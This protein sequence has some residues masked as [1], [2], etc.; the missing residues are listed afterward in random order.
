MP[1]RTFRRL[2][3]AAT[4]AASASTVALPPNFVSV[5]V[6]SNWNQ[7]VG[8]TFAPDGRMFVWEKGGRVWLVENGV[9]SAQPLIDISEE[10][11][12][13]RDF[14]LLGFAID[15][16]FYNNGYIYLLYVV[17]YHHL[18]FFGTP[19]YNPATNTYFR[20]TIGRLT[21]YQANAA[22]GFRT[23]NYNT[24]T[25][26]VGESITT[27]FPICH[28]SHGIGGL[29]F[30]ED[31]SL[32]ASCGDGAS[33][34]T[35]DS[36]GNINGSSN[37]AL[38][39]G[40]IR[41]KENVGAFRSQLVDSL[42]GKIIRINPAT[43]DGYPSNPF[44]D[45]AAPRSA[46][47]RVWSL[48]LRNPSR[49]ALRPGTGSPNPSDGMPGALYIGDVGW[50]AWEELNI[51]T[52]PGQNFGWPI[53]EGMNTLG[54]YAGLNTANQD[55]PN[56]L[57]GNGQCFQQFLFFRQLIVQD[58]LATPS[59]PNPCNSGVQLPSTLNLFEHKRPSVDWG[60][61]NGPARVPTYNGAAAAVAN[62]GAAGSPTAGAQFGGNCSI[63]GAWYTGDDFPP[64]FRNSYYHA[65]F[66]T[67]W[68]RQFI[69]NED[70]QVTEIRPFHDAAGAVVAVATDPVNGSLYYIDYNSQ[71]QSQ[72]R[73][74]Y[75][76]QNEPPTV[77]ASSNIQFGPTP[78][79]VQFS[80]AGT[81][82]PEGMFLTYDWN[83]GDGLAHSGLA[84]PTYT[85]RDIQ[86]ITHLGAFTAK[87]LSLNPPRPT[88]GG[89]WDPEV[90]RDGVYPP[91][92]SDDSQQQY[93]TFHNNDQGNE[94]WIGYTFSSTR[95]FVG[96]IFQEGKHFGDGGWFDQLRVQRRTGA[97]T[98]TDVSGLSITPVYAANNGV[99][100]ETYNISFTP[101]NG[102]GLRIYGLPGGSNNFISVGELRVLAISAPPNTGTPTLRGPLRP[103]PAP[104]GR[105][106]SRLRWR[107]SPS[108]SRG[109][110]RSSPA[111][112][113]S[114][115][116][117]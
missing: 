62:V 97:D 18:A 36:G 93:D 41:P 57:F 25:I 10:V 32:L 107:G 33:Y 85:F 98:W 65:E 45:P 110:E 11:G 63:G 47:S 81:F 30:G 60:R 94:D 101:V 3:L 91:V 27:G 103:R 46:K 99:N 21:R 92:G 14:G 84:N 12:D 20:D 38:A 109:R 113:A 75:W 58:T 87:I 77:A 54:G 29:V 42:S 112:R 53:Y 59:F 13:W 89:N 68:I 72:V 96:M 66:G 70:H 17:D 61:P 2:T 86:D 49:F 50:N 74:I 24:R 5:P 69:V 73:R 51:A 106:S 8:A 88:G 35:V 15:P 64:E 102:N 43:G 67:R 55:A 34:E 79:T 78:L 31:G 9:K 37:T 83:F 40:I 104:A 95:Q 4:L 6:A 80:S 52:G 82:D 111:W 76:T 100:Y 116:P 56:P 26:L 23:V 44:Y 28:Q 48:G 114:S 117:R 1:S 7:A 115:T 19:S 16:D 90:M 108:C 39:E 22:D 71:G 105:R